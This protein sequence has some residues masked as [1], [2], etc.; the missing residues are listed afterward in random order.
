MV[1][2]KLRG[3]Q[4]R[5]LGGSVASSAKL[6]RDQNE[7]KLSNEDSAFLWVVGS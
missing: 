1:R 3:G 4:L 2:A 7:L 6:N 5:I